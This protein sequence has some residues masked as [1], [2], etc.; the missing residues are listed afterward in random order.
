MNKTFNKFILLVFVS[1]SHIIVLF[2]LS[3]KRQVESTFL[4]KK[5]SRSVIRLNNIFV[6]AKQVRTTEQGSLKSSKQVDKEV[7]SQ[8]QNKQ[9][10]SGARTEK[11]QYITSIKE[12]IEKAKSYPF[13][14]KRLN[15]EGIVEVKFEILASGKIENLVL[16]K[17]EGDDIF[18]EHTQ[19]IF[20]SINSFDPLPKKLRGEIFKL[21]LDIV[22][23]I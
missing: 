1:L 12:K 8:S 19:N 16:D 3:N 7:N 22:Y 14:A 2:I 10:E 4:D 15:L 18:I 23:K 17:K 5:H 6:K 21:S 9:I 11:N 20:K 13:V